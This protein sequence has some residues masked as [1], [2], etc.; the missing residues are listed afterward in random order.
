MQAPERG[1]AVADRPEMSGDSYVGIF[2]FGP[3]QPF[4]AAKSPVFF[5]NQFHSSESIE[6]IGSLRPTRPSPDLSSKPH[7]ET[8]SLRCPPEDP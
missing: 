7:A 3:G 1:Q 5:N 2:E 8:R 6:P 4:I